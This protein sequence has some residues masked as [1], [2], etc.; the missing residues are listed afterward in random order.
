MAKPSSEA[1]KLN[2]DGRASAST[3]AALLA[4]AAAGS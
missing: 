1:L 3:A 4:A 2:L